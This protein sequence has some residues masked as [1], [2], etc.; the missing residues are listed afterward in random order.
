MQEAQGPR[1]TLQPES[2]GYSGPGLPRAQ[3]HEQIREG[4]QVVP[5]H[6]GQRPG[7]VVAI[8]VVGVL[9]GLG[10]SWNGGGVLDLAQGANRVSPH[11]GLGVIETL[12]QG[13]DGVFLR[14]AAQR[15]RGL[16]SHVSRRVPEGLDERPF[17]PLRTNRANEPDHQF[18]NFEI[19][20]VE[21]G[22]KIR[23]HWL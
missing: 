13:L 17:D 22:Q 4:E 16:R 10:K 14:K 6:G 8:A 5:L 1:V 21:L 20:I 11:E 3:P 9:E 15:T 2:Q 18:S 7:D 23:Q 12:F 19:G